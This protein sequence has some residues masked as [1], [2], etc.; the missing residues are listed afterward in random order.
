MSIN[1]SI[2][3]QDWTE[4]LLGL[5]LAR[6][7]GWLFAR[8]KQANLFYITFKVCR[9]RQENTMSINQPI[10]DVDVSHTM[11]QQLLLA[12]KEYLKVC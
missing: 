5:V 2:L 9:P 7:E 1:Q 8:V 10:L 11:L 4:P 3:D 6:P 12:R